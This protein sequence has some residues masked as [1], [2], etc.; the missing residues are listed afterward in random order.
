[1]K[2]L[3]ALVALASTAFVAC[4]GDRPGPSVVPPI[5]S[6]AASGFVEKQRDAVLEG[7]SAARTKLKFN[8]LFYVANDTW[9]A[10]D[11]T[12]LGT[13]FAIRPGPEHSCSGTAERTLEETEFFVPATLDNPSKPEKL[14]SLLIN[15][16]AAA[17]L[18]IL[19][20]VSASV[21]TEDVLSLTM[22]NEPRHLVRDAKYSL[23]LGKLKEKNPLLW[24]E[25]CYV[26][27]V[28]GMTRRALTYRKYSK[29]KANTE[30][31]A[32]GVRVGGNYYASDE[33]EEV[34]Y[35]FGLNL[36]GLEAPSAAP[37]D[38]GAPEGGLT[39]ASSEDALLRSVKT[40]RIRH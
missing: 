7:A 1:M 22:T 29:T 9:T 8:D 10:G 12:P 14:K 33:D 13:I 5:P 30:A 26:G 17:S 6:S 34:T 24:T 19:S 37:R 15:R 20:F 3:I 16:E 28:T 18:N 36:V 11:Q 38:G 23:E 2:R 21:G 4:S 31:G 40:V 25:N 39:A 32:Y 35:I 27:I